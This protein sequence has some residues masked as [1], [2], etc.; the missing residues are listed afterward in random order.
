M[1]G[2]SIIWYVSALI[3]NKSQIAHLITATDSSGNLLA[4]PEKA[5]KTMQAQ[6]L[7]IHSHNGWLLLLVMQFHK[8]IHRCGPAES[9]GL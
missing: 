7:V 1:K 2:I 5:W 8:H 3:D 6:G 4:T 9:T